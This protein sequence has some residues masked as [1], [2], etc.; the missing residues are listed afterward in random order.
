MSERSDPVRVALISS[1]PANPA[2]GGGTATAVLGLAR[3][4]EQLGHRVDR[5]PAGGDGRKNLVSRAL[6]NVALRNRDF[7]AFDLVIGVDLDGF[8]LRIE[9]PYVVLLKGV[10]ADEADH[11]RGPA[12]LERRL[13][14]AL[15][16]ANVRRAH[17]VVVPS[18]YAAG[19]AAAR[20]GIASDRLAVVPEP[21]LRF[22]GPDALLDAPCQAHAQP[23]IL[24]VGHQYR[25]KRT[26]DLLRAIALL[27]PHLGDARVRIVGDGPE[28]PRLR[29]LAGALRIAHRVDFLG[30]IDE[31]ALAREYATA[32]CFCHPSVQEAF[33]IVVVEAMAAGLPVVAARAA[34]VPELVQDGATGRLVEPRDPAAL[35]AALAQLLDDEPL[36]RSMGTA[37]R[38][39]AGLRSPAEHARQLLAVSSTLGAGGPDRRTRLRRRRGSRR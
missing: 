14:A 36:R 17:R 23:T 39:R 11:E 5:L 21:V 30:R 24:S 35:A 33:G 31:V 34:A 27:P 32:H 9:R 37:G 7:D 3:G 10:A 25:R 15:E 6:F 1:W 8:A 4:L 12:V 38:S 2:S 18:A 29:R 16:A 20:Y 13:A 28:L 22:E 19:I 26:A